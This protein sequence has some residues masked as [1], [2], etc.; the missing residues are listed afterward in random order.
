MQNIQGVH[1][2]LDNQFIIKKID[3]FY[4]QII[5]QYLIDLVQI[6][7]SYLIHNNLY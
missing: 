2:N 4:A 1:K 3:V 7:I 6:D 5:F